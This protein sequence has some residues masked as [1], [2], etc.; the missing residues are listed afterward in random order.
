ML[1]LDRILPLLFVNDKLD[2]QINLCGNLLLSPV[3]IC[4]L[5]GNLLDNAMEANKQI[6]STAKRRIDLIL[7]SRS[8]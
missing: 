2:A 3:E 7:S 1:C 5:F 8:I 4:I 6:N